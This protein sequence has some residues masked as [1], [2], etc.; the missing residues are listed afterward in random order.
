MEITEELRQELDATGAALLE[1]AQQVRATRTLRDP[2]IEAKM[3]GEW[4][5]L[6]RYFAGPRVT[7][8]ARALVPG[9]NRAARNFARKVRTA[10]LRER[11][12]MTDGTGNLMV[13]IARL[14]TL[15]S[16]H[17]R[18]D[19]SYQRP[20]AGPHHPNE[21][22]TTF[23]ISVRLRPG[24]EP[25]MPILVGGTARQLACYRR[26]IRHALAREVKA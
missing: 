3:G 25:G 12:E 2:V 13:N 19:A 17:R 5:D 18:A 20:A 24:D 23:G 1:E 6:S 10:E 4:R 26:A 14:A 22:L 7:R 9:P 16:E 15:R 11:L 8:R 21:R